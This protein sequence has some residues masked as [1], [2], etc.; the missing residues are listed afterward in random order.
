MRT[1]RSSQTLART[2]LAG[3]LALT[4]CAATE[5]Y[6]TLSVL[7]ATPLLVN[8]LSGNTAPVHDPSIIRQAG[9]YYLFTSD[10]ENPKPHQYLPIRCSNDGVT[11]NPCGQIFTR[12]PAWVHSINS[13]IS[14]LW[15]PDISYFNGLYHLYYAASTNG[16]QASAI[17]LATNTTLNPADPAY[18]WADQG[19]VITSQPGDDF[20]AIDPNIL[21]DADQRVWLTYGSYWSGIKQREI[22]PS[23]GML[24]ASNPT[25]Y[26]LAARPGTPDHAIE[27]SSLVHHGSF[28]YL[29]LSV[30]HCC[31]ASTSE[32]NYKQIVGRSSSPNGPFFDATGAALNDGGGSILLSGNTTWM[33]PGGG[34]AYID[35]ESGDSLLVFH[36]LQMAN[37]ATP[38]LWVKTITWQNDWPVLN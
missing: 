3:L 17:G 26:Q 13:G 37:S 15:A 27:G 14:D 21:V 12:I 24:L 32:D 20:N 22:D 10:P 4:A 5:R 28:Y 8:S 35:P 30:D 2:L 36:A 16:S 11:W 29:F 7:E 34:T 25:R 1:S 6:Q 9:T 18:R 33:A 19:Q 23:N 31:A 38:A